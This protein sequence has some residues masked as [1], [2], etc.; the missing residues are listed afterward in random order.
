MIERFPLLHLLT[1]QTSPIVVINGLPG[2]GKSV[3]LRQLADYFNCDVAN[4]LPNPLDFNDNQHLIWDTIGRGF[5]QHLDQVLRLCPEL[6]SR[7]QTLFISASWIGNNKVISEALLYGKLAIIDQSELMFSEQ[8]IAILHPSDSATI[9]LHTRGWPVLVSNWKNLDIE[10]YKES[11]REYVSARVLPILSYHE[12]QLLIALAFSSTISTD[13]VKLE[14]TH[15]DMLDPLIVE[16]RNGNFTLGIPYLKQV[17]IDITKPDSRMY[18]EA[19]RLVATHN[20]HQKDHFTAIKMAINS[21]NLNLAIRWFEESGGGM[22]GYQHGFAKL[23][24]LLTFF[25]DDMIKSNLNLCLAK[26]VF[27][28][29]NYRLLEARNFIETLNLSEAIHNLEEKDQVIANLIQGNYDAYF[30]TTPDDS[31]SEHRQKLEFQLASNP[32]ALM[33]YYGTLSI[34]SIMLGDWFQASLYQHKELELANKRDVPYLVFYC[35]FNLAR[36]NLRMGYPKVA[37]QHVKESRKNLTRVSFY[38]SLS[39]ER[40]FPDLIDGMTALYRADIALAN[41]QWNRTEILRKHSEVWPEFLFQFYF[42]GIACHL[43][44]NETELAGSLLDQLRYEY[45]FFFTDDQGKIYFKLLSSLILQQ[46]QRWI[47]AQNKLSSIDVNTEKMTGPISG[48]YNWLAYRNNVGLICIHSRKQGTVVS[49]PLDDTPWSEICYT[50]QDL[51]L[52]WFSNEH[53][54]LTPRLLSLFRRAYTLDL[55]LPLIFEMEWLNQAVKK[56][57]LSAKSRI[58]HTAYERAFSVWT[59]KCQQTPNQNSYADEL[60]PKQLLVVQRLG[61]GLSNKQIAQFTG[62]SES[63]VKFHL[64]GLFKRF[65]VSSRQSLV[66]LAT[67]KGWIH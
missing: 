29:K 63:T 34:S 22:Y 10:R 13:L 50:L 53:Q 30:A 62:L 21:N 1:A 11:L 19:I 41:R 67:E 52:L 18:Q 56:V 46:Q 28:L 57:K 55:W 8:E 6:E 36:I 43:V 58:K 20:F 12:Q 31:Q 16:D 4:T 59:E 42:F 65:S 17:F 3:I 7:G 48:F 61:E 14:K 35:H 54:V 23:E 44:A 39:F 47:E 33:S 26:T 24:Q 5:H 66:K 49:T 64:K 45:Q 2:S 15:I 60:T 32:D 40:N 38:Q 27:Y 37:S 9:Y 51:K 25:S